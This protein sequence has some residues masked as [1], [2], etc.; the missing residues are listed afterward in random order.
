MEAWRD[1]DNIDFDFI[2][3]HDINVALDTSQP[4][5]IRKRLRER[6]NNTKQVVALVSDTSEAKSAR[7]SSFLYYE[8]ETISS[9]GLP[10]VFANI[11]GS[12]GVQKSKLPKT[13]IEHYTVSVSFQAKIIQHALDNYVVDYG[14][15]LTSQ[16]PKKGPH[17]YAESVYKSLNL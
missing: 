15:N 1:R 11:N 10:V 6:L 12:R 4:E 3:A 14:K 7:S 16:A 9:L 5:T 2:D 8:I 17:L 13:L